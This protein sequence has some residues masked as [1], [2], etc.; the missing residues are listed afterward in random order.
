MIET[1]D[2]VLNTFDGEVNGV[3]TRQEFNNMLRDPYTRSYTPVIRETLNKKM[4]G[5]CIEDAYYLFKEMADEMKKHCG[6][7]Y[8]FYK[9]GSFKSMALNQ[10]CKNNITVQPEA[11]HNTEASWIEE[12]SSGGLMYWEPYEGP[13][14]EYDIN[15]LYSSIM[16]KNQ[17]YFPIKEGEFTTISE[18]SNKMEHGI[19]RCKITKEDD[20]PYKFF[21]FNPKN[22][23][24]HVDIEVALAY[25]L[26]V[27][28][29]A[30][31][32]P[33][34]LI[35]TKDKLMNGAYLFKNY[36]DELYQ[37]KMNKVVGA[38]DLLN[39]L[40]GGLCES[41]CYKHAIEFD[42]END[43]SEAHIRKINVGDKI[44]VNCTYFKKKQYKMNWARIKPFILAYARSRMF[45]CFKKF[46]PLIIRMHTDGIY[47]KEQSTELKTGINIGYLKYVGEWH[48]NI[49]GIN[50][51][52]KRKI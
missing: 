23:Y 30:D 28:L 25:G 18:V 47:L 8:N 39:V 3:I 37:L 5:Q 16:Q 34:A 10:F 36:I 15:S 51:L 12:G 26:K 32:K 29:I 41:T 35:Y 52:S 13:I 27:E 6:G 33:N 11:I 1:I 14:N 21:R 49:T 31:D 44:R 20:Q 43:I 19:Y 2:D 42:E 7:A 22:K 45:F 17:H 46:E 50:N 38:K 24:T 48:V 9:C 40:W 4:Q